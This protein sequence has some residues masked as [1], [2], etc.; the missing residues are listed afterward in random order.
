M[1]FSIKRW[2][3]TWLPRSSQ[4]IKKRKK[5]A[6]ACL[7]VTL[8]SAWAPSAEAVTIQLS[9]TPTET[10]THAYA[11]Y[12]I[13]FSS[14]S[15]FRYYASEVPLGTLPGQQTTTFEHDFPD[16][17]PEHFLFP[18]EWFD[19][20]AGYVLFGLYGEPGS[21]GVSLSFPSDAPITNGATWDTLIRPHLPEDVSEAEWIADF[22][23][24]GEEDEEPEMSP[25]A[26][27]GY[28]DL[29]NELSGLTRTRFGSPATLVNFS[30]AALGGGATA[31]MVPEPGSGILLVT[32]VGLW[33][34]SRRRK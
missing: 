34:V 26:S 9:V 10:L 19:L 16:V 5:L 14:G 11:L 3:T 24:P 15:P 23:V 32:G 12:F 22:L 31:A 4:F 33:L 7:A 6:A 20:P 13:H 28:R 30:A 27:L 8:A 25:L 1:I 21:Q 18:E 29:S 2:L 17:K